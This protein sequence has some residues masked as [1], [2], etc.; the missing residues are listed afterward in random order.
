ML[1]GG[2][3]GQRGA[4]ITDRLAA[5]AL[6]RTGWLGWLSCNKHTDP[7]IGAQD[8]WGGQPLSVLHSSLIWSTTED[9]GT[10]LLELTSTATW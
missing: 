8:E 7:P 4:P 9:H 3:A 6:P 5:S 2:A 10:E 1:K